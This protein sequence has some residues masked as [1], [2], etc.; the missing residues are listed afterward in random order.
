L[1]PADWE[2]TGRHS[3]FGPTGIVDWLTYYAEH[4]REHADQIRRARAVSAVQE[5]QP[6]ASTA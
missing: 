4:P 3:E 5:R 2:R 1:Q 6:S